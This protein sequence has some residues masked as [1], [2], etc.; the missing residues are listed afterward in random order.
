L[1]FNPANVAVVPVPVVVLPPGDAV[2]VHVPEA[3]N[4]VI[5]T[6]P[7]ATAHVG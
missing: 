2:I 7:V 3:G 4:P 5:A 1:G 6:L